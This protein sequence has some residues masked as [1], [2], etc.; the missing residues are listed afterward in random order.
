MRLCLRRLVK[1]VAQ[2]V[3]M[4]LLRRGICTHGLDLTGYC[5]PDAGIVAGPPVDLAKEAVP[6]ERSLV[7]V[8][9]TSSSLLWPDL[10]WEDYSMLPVGGRRLRAPPRLLRPW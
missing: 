3:D 4:V 9:A 8:V 10:E 1:L 7:F 6:P 2:D 5:P